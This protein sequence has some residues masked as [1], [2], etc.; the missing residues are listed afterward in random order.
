MSFPVELTICHNAPVVRTKN[1]R[2]MCI[3]SNCAK[4]NTSVGVILMEDMDFHTRFGM[5]IENIYSNELTEFLR[6]SH[7][8]F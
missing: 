4:C 3:Y 7:G 2:D 5:L 6:N 8:Y 1:L